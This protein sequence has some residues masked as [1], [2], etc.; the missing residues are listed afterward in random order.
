MEPIAALSLAANI[1]QIIDFAASLVSTSQQIY[2]AG[3]SVK[4]REVELS[5]R[6]FN[7]LNKTLKSW[8]RPDVHALGPLTKDQ[9]DLEILALES[10]KVA[11]ELLDALS[12]LRLYGPPSK[13]DSVA[14]AL[15][16]AWNKR[17]ID[18]IK[19]R[20]GE[21]R[22]EIQFRILVTS[23]DDRVKELDRVEQAIVKCVLDDKDKLAAAMTAHNADSAHRH[24]QSEAIASSR[25]EQLV[26]LIYGVGLT[27]I[28]NDDNSKEMEAIKKIKVALDFQI[29][30]DRFDDIA[31]AHQRTFEWVLQGSTDEQATWSNLL[32][33]LKEGSGIYWMSGKAGSGKSTLVKF[34]HRHKRLMDALRVWADGCRLIVLRYYFWNAGTEIQKSQ[35]GLLRSL[36]YQAIDQAPML[37]PR[38]FPDLYEDLIEQS[39]SLLPP[40]S[41]GPNKLGARWINFPTFHEL[42]RAFVTLTTQFDGLH[43]IV[44][45]VDGLDEFETPRMSMTELADVFIAASKLHVKALLSSRPLPAFEDAF[46]ALPK[47]RLHQLTHDDITTYVHDKLGLHPRVEELTME[48]PEGAKALITSIV[49]SASGV[50]LW[51]SLVVESLIEG[52][53][54]YDTL[55]D[56][57][58]RLQELPRDLEELFRHML[59]KIPPEYKEQSSRFFQLIRSNREQPTNQS[60]P[61]IPTALTAVGLYYAEADL[62]VIMKATIYHMPEEEVQTK[63]RKVEGRLRSRCAGLLEL[64]ARKNHVLFDAGHEVVY[65]HRSVADFL[66]LPEVWADIAGFS[67]AYDPC[68]PLIQSL[69]M[70][71]KRVSV[72]S[73]GKLSETWRYVNAIMHFARL[74]ESTTKTTPRELLDEMDRSMQYHFECLPEYKNYCKTWYETNP[75]GL[76]HDTFLSFT[77]QQKLNIYAHIEPPGRKGF[78]RQ[79]KERL[80]AVKTRNSR[81]AL[82]NSS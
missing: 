51:V 76:S 79:M 53:Q 65:L 10:E 3:S 28:S 54:N 74:V 35:E 23:N 9:Q 59:R 37:G 77:V 46:A 4:V 66:K 45:I 1:L 8:V 64:R 70:R 2:E 52:L 78:L 21:L 68:I 26:S 33:W 56:L 75:S 81:K 7:D 47:L 32:D 57:D 24:Q 82:K 12:G 40:F 43:K 13:F 80:D 48:D 25:H 69:L 15:K 14:R 55:E 49:D 44:M 19:H 60:F 6:D 20:L 22:Q 16:T 17:K 11:Q 42:K 58:R 62:N 73:P 39:K 71:I 36:I 18:D 63:V 38:L 50:F 30:E 34:L 5:V 29:M 61:Y 67:P 72:D 41:L 27:N 31:T